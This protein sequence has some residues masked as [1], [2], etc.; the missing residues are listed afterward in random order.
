[1]PAASTEIFG[2]V[3]GRRP[4]Y[5]TQMTQF[6]LSAVQAV[7][8]SASATL[9]VQ[10]STDSGANWSNLESSG[11]AG[12]LAVGAGTGLKVGAWSTIASAALTDVQIRLIGFS[13]DGA[14]DPS[15][16]YIGVE[17]R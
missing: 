2:T 6:R 4:A 16:R 17:F 14:T 7:A 3:W 13:G 9:R 1:M 10:Y 11:T 5:L 15:F 8:G 12:D